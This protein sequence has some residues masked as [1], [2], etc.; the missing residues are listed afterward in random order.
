MGIVIT[1]QEWNLHECYPNESILHDSGHS[2][3][4]GTYM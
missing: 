4:L 2:R 3:A 1:Q